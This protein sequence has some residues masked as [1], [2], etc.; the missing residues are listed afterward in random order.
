MYD[1]CL[2][3]FYTF[4]FSFENYRNSIILLYTSITG[5]ACV[6]CADLRY[7]GNSVYPSGQFMW[8]L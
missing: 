8:T 2:P 7:L 5:L 1:V 6:V 3:N 4:P